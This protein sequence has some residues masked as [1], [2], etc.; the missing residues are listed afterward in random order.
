M[1]EPTHYCNEGIMV[2]TSVDKRLKMDACA[3]RL[4]T[5]ST[6]GLIDI[7]E[8]GRHGKGATRNPQAMNP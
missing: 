7:H 4:G 5:S 8:D 1:A 6:D 3:L 2:E